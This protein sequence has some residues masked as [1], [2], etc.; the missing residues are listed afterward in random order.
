MENSMLK[1]DIKKKQNS[2]EN[3]NENENHSDKSIST[4]RLG[5][6]DILALNNGWNANNEKFIVSIGENAA[7]YKYMHEKVSSRYVIYDRIIKIFITILTVII[8]AEYYIAIF[9]TNQILTVIQAV[10][11][12]ILA[13]MSLIYNFL[14]YVELSKDHANTASLFGVLYHDIR[15]IMCLYRKDRPNA[16]RYIQRA[17]KEYDHLEVNGP[18]IPDWQLTDFQKKFEKANISMP[19]I[20]D[21]IQKI[22][23]IQEPGNNNL[24]VNTKNIENKTSFKINNNNNLSQIQECFKID[25]DLSENDNLTYVDLQ[26]RK[27]NL[28]K[29]SDYEMKRF[30]SHIVKNNPEDLV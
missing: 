27:E 25:G 11:T 2:D 5:K 16:V 21:R 22:E 10:I 29:Q 23:I 17:I 13:V 28:N 9:Q 4:Q 18:N 8:S 3:E 30:M 26:K 7:S 19:D 12:T 6:L 1:I 20:T 14:N 24:N 15:N